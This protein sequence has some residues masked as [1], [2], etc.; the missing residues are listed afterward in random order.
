MKKEL[1][2][3]LADVARYMRERFPEAKDFPDREQPAV[4]QGDRAEITKRLNEVYSEEPS[5]LDPVVAAIQAASLPH[6]DW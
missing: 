3:T 2:K 5:D 6:D 4:R 1:L